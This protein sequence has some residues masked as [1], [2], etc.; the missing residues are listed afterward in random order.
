MINNI[1][2]FIVGFVFAKGHTKATTPKAKKQP[3]L[4][5]KLAERAKIAFLFED[6]MSADALVFIE[7][8]GVLRQCETCHWYF[9]SCDVKKYIKDLKRFDTKGLK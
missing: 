6:A 3:C 7:T 9:G 2:Y 8:G 4:E 1:I 5:C